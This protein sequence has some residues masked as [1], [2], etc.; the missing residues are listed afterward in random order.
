M[1][2]KDLYTHPILNDSIS[3]GLLSALSVTSQYQNLVSIYS[4]IFE[5]LIEPINYMREQV[6][7]SIDYSVCTA[8]ISSILETSLLPI[9]DTIDIKAITSNVIQSIYADTHIADAIKSISTE[10]LDLFSGYGALIESLSS[11]QENEIELILEGTEFTTDEVLE[12]IKDLKEEFTTETLA[13]DTLLLK[14]KWEAFLRKHPALANVIFVMGMLI[15]LTSGILA[16]NDIG[17]LVVSTTQEVIVSTQDNEDIFFIKV[18]SAK[19]YTEPSSHSAVKIYILYG[20]QVTLIES[21]NLWDKVIYIN[22]DGEE[23]TGWIAKRNLM[24]YQDYQFNSDDL[25]DMK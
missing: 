5:N 17:E 21:I 8:A 6:L 10:H 23:I 18:D 2:N 25:Y 3:E 24:T 16:V 14:D 12:D 22:Q 1:D 9:L 7:G 4:P 13:E 15:G 19:L 20:E 11:L